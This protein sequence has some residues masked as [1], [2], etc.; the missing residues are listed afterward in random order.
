MDE[1]LRGTRAAAA[2]ADMNDSYR[3]RQVIQH[4]RVD[5]IIDQGHR[6]TLQRL[7]GL[8]GEQL[9]ITRASPHQYDPAP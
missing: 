8:D 9:R 1:R 5:E 3:R 7:D 2:F 6:R 4:T